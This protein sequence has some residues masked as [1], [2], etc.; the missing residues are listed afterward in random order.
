VP[1]TA[2]V[3]AGHY[4]LFFEFGVMNRDGEFL[5]LSALPGEAARLSSSRIARRLGEEN[6]TFEKKIVLPMVRIGEAAPPKMPWALLFDREVHGVKGVV[7]D[8]DR[9]AWALNFRNRLHSRPIYPKGRYDLEPGFPS[10]AYESVNIDYPLAPR[11]GELTVR[12]TGPDGKT[13]DLGTAPFAALTRWGATTRTGRFRYDFDRYGEYRIVMKGWVRDA[14]GNRFDG[15]GTYRIWIAERITFGTFPSNPYEVGQTFLSA[16][17]VVPAVPAKVTLTIEHYPDSDVN[18][19]TTFRTAGVANGLG[20]FVAP[21]RYVFPSPGEYRA[22]MEAEYVDPEGRLW[23]GSL[24]SANV[25]APKDSVMVAHGNAGY[26]ENG[27]FHATAPRFSLGTA[28]N[29]R[30]GKIQFVYYPFHAGDVLYMPS[31]MDH[32]NW[33]FPL[34]TVEFLD[35]FVPYGGSLGDLSAYPLRPTTPSGDSPFCFP[36]EIDRLAYY[37]A[38]GWRPGVCGRH[39][40]GTAQMMNSYW[41]VSPSL[42]GRQMHA[43]A[44]GDLPGDIYRFTGGAVYRD[45]KTGKNHYAIYVATGAI[46]AATDLDNRVTAP[47]QEPLLRMNGRAHY[48]LLGGAVLPVP[49]MVLAEG[50]QVPVGGHANPAV[51]ARLESVVTTPSGRELRYHQKANRLGQFPRGRYRASLDEPGAW[52]VRHRLAYAG[53]TGDVLGSEDGEYSF[54]VIPAEADRV[55]ELPLD[56]PPISRIGPGQV[57]RLSGAVPAGVRDGL[58]HYTVISP[59]VILDEGTLPV[60]DG[61]FCYEF[62][63]WETGRRVPFYD[64]SD[65]LTGEPTLSDTVVITLFLEGR[66]RDG[67]NVYAHRTVAMRGSTVINLPSAKRKHPTPPSARKH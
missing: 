24:W 31:T 50:G 19:K 47:C 33:I 27:I 30:E 63:P 53:K 29:A 35:R 51:P 11:S 36:E 55:Y 41:S 34:L 25:V 3:P 57:V 15:G 42:M 52:R 10:L 49:G 28:G 20:A 6:L 8:E 5:R 38:D 32:K 44:N 16:V 12:V 22:R 14:Y 45:L 59:G 65:Y 23:L 13:V 2:R 56:L 43:S 64:T 58:L 40:V 9:R 4:R 37:Y 21:R 66:R 67:T 62:D 26:M 1:I 48:L 54:Y 18:R 17:G 60:M 46:T 61:V 7:P 39:V